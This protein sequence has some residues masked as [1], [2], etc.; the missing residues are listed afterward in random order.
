[1][2]VVVL[3][4]CLAVLH[5]P[6]FGQVQPY[7]V[8]EF[9]VAAGFFEEDDQTISTRMLGRHFVTGDIQI[10]ECRH[11]DDWASGFRFRVE[12]EDEDER[13]FVGVLCDPDTGEQLITV[14]H[15]RGGVESDERVSSRAEELNPIVNQMMPMRVSCY[16]GRLEISV[17][18][19]EIGKNLDFVPGEFFIFGFGAKGTARFYEL[20][21]ATS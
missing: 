16:Q 20:A 19:V 1:M 18:G 6:A 9:D 5:F 4:I 7:H 17:N 2:R 12:S 11:H 14:D 8:F 21:G 13:V 10:Q 3:G 15:F